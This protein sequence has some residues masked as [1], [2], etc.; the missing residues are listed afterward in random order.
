MRQSMNNAC[1]IFLVLPT[2]DLSAPSKH[3]IP[4]TKTPPD[5][6]NPKPHRIPE[7][8]AVASSPTPRHP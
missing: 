6:G 2:T 4:A 8:A 1:R 3:D 7:T 5:F